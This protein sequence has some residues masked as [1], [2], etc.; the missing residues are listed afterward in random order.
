LLAL[1]F[2]GRARRQA[3]SEH[4]QTRRD[5]ESGKNKPPEMIRCSPC[6]GGAPR[7]GEVRVYAKGFAEVV[8]V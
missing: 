6:K 7:I 5:E 2:K 4:R 1:A 8:L 3:K